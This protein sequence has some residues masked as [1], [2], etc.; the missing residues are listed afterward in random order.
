MVKNVVHNQYKF[1]NYI[2]L[3]TRW[4]NSEEQKNLM[5]SKKVQIS[6]LR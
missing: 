4:T 6:E 2:E 5:V 1:N 3:G